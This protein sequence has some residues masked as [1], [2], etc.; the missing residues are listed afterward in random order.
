LV[1][2]QLLHQ[3]LPD[4]GVPEAEAAVG[5]FDHEGSH[6]KLELVVGLVLGHIRHS[7]QLVGAERQAQERHP[8]E[9]PK[10]IRRQDGR[11]GGGP[12][13]TRPC[14]LDHGE[15]QAASGLAHLLHGL[16]VEIGEP[17]EQQTL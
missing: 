4:E 1:R 11:H 10:R 5:G 13:R 9:R 6:G 3:S 12:A 14:H 7:Q 15:G 2:G 16:P 17:V 8:L